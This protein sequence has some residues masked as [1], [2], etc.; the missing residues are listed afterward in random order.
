MDIQ[1]LKYA[2]AYFAYTQARPWPVHEF[3]V[4]FAQN[5]KEDKDQE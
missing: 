2:A 5:K 4:L 1:K 3:L